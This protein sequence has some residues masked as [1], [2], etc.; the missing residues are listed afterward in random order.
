MAIERDAGP[1]GIIGPQLPEVQPDEVLVEGLPQ[2]PGVFEF[3]D[4]SAI[5]GEYAEEEEIPQIS[6]DS[7]LAEFMDSS[8]LG[9][10]SSDLT[11]EIDDDISSRQDWQDTYKRG[12]EFLG[13][14]YEDRA[15][16]FEGSSGVIHP[17]LAE[18]VTQFQAQA[19]REMLPAS[20]PVRTQV[21]G[22]QSEQ[23]IK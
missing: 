9:K 12:L 20:G 21:V 4:G 15:E 16:P 23:L 6:H 7:N 1:G 11:G 22:A 8:D 3:D 17:L 14:Q 10:I 2:D 18:S 19:Y 5:I 13:M